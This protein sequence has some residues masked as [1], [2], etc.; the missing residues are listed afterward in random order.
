MNV[1]MWFQKHGSDKWTRRLAA[2]V[3]ALAL[4]ASFTTYEFVKPA[5]A[6]AAAIAPAPAA[7]ALDADSVSALLALDRAMEN[8]AAHVTSGGG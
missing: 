5:A 6:R 7:P 2:P 8:L 4:A 1:R 3:L